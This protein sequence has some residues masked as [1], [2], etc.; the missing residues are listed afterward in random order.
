MSEY[1][2]YQNALGIRCL[3]LHRSMITMESEASSAP[4]PHPL[5]AVGSYDN[6][7]RELSVRSWSV[8]FELPL[9]HPSEMLESTAAGVITTVEVTD[10]DGAEDNDTPAAIGKASFSLSRYDIFKK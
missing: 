3:A 9:A 5:F 7:I 10:R 6:V 8:A 4:M 2:A 1:E